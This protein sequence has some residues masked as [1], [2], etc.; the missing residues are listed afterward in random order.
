MEVE[1]VVIEFLLEEEEKDAFD[2]EQGNYYPRAKLLR[3]KFF[4]NELN[5]WPQVLSNFDNVL[6]EVVEESEVERWVGCLSCNDEEVNQDFPAAR[7]FQP[8]NKLDKCKKGKGRHDWDKKLIEVTE[9][10]GPTADKVLCSDTENLSQGD[11]SP[12]RK[13][14]GWKYAVVIC[15]DEYTDGS[16]FPNLTSARADFQPLIETLGNDHGYD[17]TMMGPSM[18]EA[19]ERDF[20]NTD[21]VYYTLNTTITTLK[22]KMEQ[23]NKIKID[24]FL[25]YFIGHGVNSNG[26]DCMAGTTGNVTTINSTLKQDGDLKCSA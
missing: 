18:E 2:D 16:G 25:F 12:L 10:S 19:E 14:K 15:N 6:M 7:C 9:N 23:K 22:E 26:E 1:D 3:L 4:C 24:S 5:K 11:G 13:D 21:D 20:I 8:V 17:L